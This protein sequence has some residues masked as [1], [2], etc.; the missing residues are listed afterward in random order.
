MNWRLAS[1]LFTIISTVAMGLLLTISLILGYDS[2]V[3]ILAAVCG[4]FVLALPIT[5][6][7]TKRLVAVT[8]QDQHT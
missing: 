7:I 1:V 5:Y 6:L 3:M 2:A 4:G 8:A